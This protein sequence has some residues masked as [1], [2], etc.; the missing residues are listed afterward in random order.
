V[1]AAS[2]CRVA[3]TTTWFVVGSR[4]QIIDTERGERREV[5]LNDGS[6]V[7]VDPESHLRLKFEDQSRNVYL[8]RGR[9]LFHVAKNL[10]RPFLVHANGTVVCAV[11]TAFGVERQKQ[12]IVVTVAEGTVAVFLSRLSSS[13]TQPQSTSPPSLENPHP[14]PLASHAERG[15]NK[16]TQ[17]SNSPLWVRGQGWARQR[18]GEA[19]YGGE[20]FSKS[21]E[22][23]LTANQQITVKT[24]GSAEPVLKVDSSRELAWA[25]G[26]LVFKNTPV[27][28][29]L[30]QFN[31]YNRIHLH[32]S[33]AAIA[34][35]PI[36]GVF[37]A[38]DPDSFIAFVESVVPVRVT[39]DSDQDITI[40]PAH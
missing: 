29:V 38:S 30:E 22:I 1:N 21:G 40:A 9:A 17:I 18:E 13:P 33:D 27:A 7:Q 32:V 14:L 25:Q 20:H 2:V 3:I 24:A 19:S 16:E 36:S 39:R 34:R 12:G 35:R 5:S 23:F 31:R 37:D 28:E 26:R 15:A 6:L 11:G 8:E 4:G 10:N